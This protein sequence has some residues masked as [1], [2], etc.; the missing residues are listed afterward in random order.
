[1]TEVRAKQVREANPFLGIDCLHNNTNGKDPTVRRCQHC[2][3]MSKQ[4]RHD[5]E[6]LFCFAPT[7]MK[8]QHVVETLI[9]KKQQILLATQVVKMILK[10]DDIRS[11]GEIE[12]WRPPRTLTDFWAEVLGTSPE[13]HVQ[14]ALHIAIYHLIQKCSSCCCIKVTIKMLVRWTFQTVVLIS[15][16]QFWTWS[17]LIFI[18]VFHVMFTLHLK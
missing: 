3:L 5:I 13:H 11:P 10:I 1:M 16:P 9:G 8:Q 17:F 4:R 18:C 12:D 6:G 15:S 7:D 2:T 14:T